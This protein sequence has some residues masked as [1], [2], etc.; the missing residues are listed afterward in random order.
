[1]KIEFLSF[2]LPMSDSDADSHANW[3]G[4]SLSGFRALW[5]EID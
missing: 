1:M 5:H 3:Y 2:S 4:I